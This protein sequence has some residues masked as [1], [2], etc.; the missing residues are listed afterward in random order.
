MSKRAVAILFSCIAIVFICGVL[1]LMLATSIQRDKETAAR[2]STSAAASAVVP[3]R[4][5]SP[6]A[7]HMPTA[8]PSGRQSAT[9]TVRGP[10]NLG[11]GSSSAAEPSM[12]ALPKTGEPVHVS[13]YVIGGLTMAL[14]GAG[15]VLAARMRVPR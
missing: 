3:T 8:R 10:A 9:P 7:G 6:S 15:L 13:W 14:G 12:T 5:L 11:G 1:A 4:A 2:A